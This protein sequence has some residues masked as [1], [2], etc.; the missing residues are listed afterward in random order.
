MLRLPRT[1]LAL[2]GAA[3]MTALAVAPVAAAGGSQVGSISCGALRAYVY[4]AAS[5]W[6]HQEWTGGGVWYYTPYRE[7]KR[8][9]TGQSSVGWKVTWDF[10]KTSV[11]A[12]CDSI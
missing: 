5:V 8:T 2:V 7:Y 12:L 6:V 1:S 9:S 11:G 10:E 4:S 3:L